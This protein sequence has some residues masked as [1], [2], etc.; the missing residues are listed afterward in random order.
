[1]VI[2]IHR[3]A[4]GR[5]LQILEGTEKALFPPRNT[6]DDRSGHSDGQGAPSLTL[7]RRLSA[8]DVDLEDARYDP[9]A[10]MPPLVRAM[11]LLQWTKNLLVFAALIFA[12]SVFDLDP[13]LR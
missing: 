5:V 12:R 13:L 6:D 3:R 8:D 7:L 10:G 2:V 1:M 11:R 9:F 4:A